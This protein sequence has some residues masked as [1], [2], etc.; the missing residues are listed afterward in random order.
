MATVLGKGTASRRSEVP[1]DLELEEASASLDFDEEPPSFERLEGLLEDEP[2]RL[3]LEGLPD[4][5]FVADLEED[6]IPMKLLYHAGV[7]QSL[8]GSRQ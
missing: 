7:C 6:M 3:L 4:E 8:Y 1:R 5:L 2:D